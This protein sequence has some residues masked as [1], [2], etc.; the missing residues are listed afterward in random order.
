[1][2][3]SRTERLFFRANRPA[4]ATD[5]LV[6]VHSPGGHAVHINPF[7]SPVAPTYTPTLYATWSEASTAMPR[8]KRRTNGR[9]SQSTGN[10]DALRKNSRRIAF[11]LAA[12]SNDHNVQQRGKIPDVTAAFTRCQ[13]MQH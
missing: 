9:T 7:S 3:Q 1:M 12:A 2:S 8:L 13:L 6:N 10:F 5:S 11:S 4:L